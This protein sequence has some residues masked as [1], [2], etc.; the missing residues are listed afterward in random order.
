MTA[1]AKPPIRHC[2]LCGVAMQGSRSRDDIRDFDRFDC[3]TCHTVIELPPP[4]R[5]SEPPPR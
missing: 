2:P 4:P 3:L 1:P 5:R